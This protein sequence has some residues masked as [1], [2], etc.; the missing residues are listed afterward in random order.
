MRNSSVGCPPILGLFQKRIEGDDAL[1]RLAALRF[2]EAGLGAELYADSFDELDWLMSFGPFPGSHIVVHL[3]R[4]LDLF[5]Q[6]ARQLVIDFAT[7]YA[8][9][10]FGLVLHD[11]KNIASRFDEY[12]E[13]LRGIEGTLSALEK[14]PFLFIEYASGLEPGHFVG[15]FEK[16]SDLRHI[17]AC[18]D[19]G[20]VGL[21]QAENVYSR[22][23]P[24]KDIHSVKTAT[25]ELPLLI[26]DM[27]GALRS[28]LDAV[29]DVVRQLSTLGKHLHFHLHDAHPFSVSGPY[30]V[31]DH[32]SF[33]EKIPI[34]F[35]YKGKR[36]LHPMFGPEGL[37]KI[38]TVVRELCPSDHITLSLEIHA[39]QGKLP[40]GDASYLFT[41][42][43]DRGNA[44]W[45][46]FWLSVLRQNQKLV[47]TFCGHNVPP[48][49]AEKMIIY[50]LF[51]LLGGPFTCWEKHLARAADMGFTWIFVNP[52]QVPGASG[53]IY[54]IKDY[55]SFNPLLV[56]PDS[57]DAPHEQVKGMIKTAQDLGL[58]VM[59]DLVINHCAAD[60]H[61][62]TS[63]PRWFLREPD[64]RIAHP[65]AY[66]DR[67]KV[68]WKDLAQFDHRNTPDKEGLFLYFFRIVEFLIALGFR[69][70]RCDAAYQVPGSLWK[71]LITETKKKYAGILFLAETLGS[72][73][74]LT[75][76]T[77]A[78]GFDYIFNSAKWW[79]FSSPW[80]MEQYN[81]TRNMAPSISFPESH[82][83]MRL[84]EE[85]K[86][87]REELKQ[88]Y[89]FCA[90]FSAGVM[91][92]MCFEFGFHKKL[93]VVK[94]RPSDWET[95]DI[96]ISSFIR[97]VNLLKASHPVFLEDA[98]TGMLHQG[99][100]NLLLMW[101]SSVRTQEECLVILNKDVVRKQH[102]HTENVQRFF[103][104]GAPLKDVS[105]GT[106]LAYIP[107][108]FS[109]DLE[110][111]QG[112]IFVSSRDL[113]PED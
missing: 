28:G 24:A 49:Q 98:P 73:P 66:E 113:V 107:A 101:K 58:R 19:I 64:G 57:D 105:P 108:P 96:D 106:R 50:N 90:L 10:V 31:S 16:I 7:R 4:G 82:D 44:E 104:S 102:F 86:G 2:R 3:R 112:I 75:R 74:E 25:E 41:H 69:G 21:W 45:M 42:W 23:H 37:S 15:I 52:I 40:L 55:F 14:S 30:G 61:L 95:T 27:E 18:I 26:E 32:L 38:L 46:N 111:G 97:E 103:Q 54:S 8:G 20:H 51:P 36:F 53:S 91:V 9:R 99:N 87:N 78:A 92:P 84:A 83:T 76:K 94:T 68:I 39:A 71:R 1:L 80:L 17:S 109:Y 110:P 88:R 67:K 60:S 59:T 33:L 35:E 85:L 65:F 81:L 62:V 12:I 56:D 29:L 43:S 5:D 89:L 48:V 77:A 22:S 34:P 72:P 11:Q 100:P 93:H 79:D 6:Q 63:H 70:F 13:V 47:L